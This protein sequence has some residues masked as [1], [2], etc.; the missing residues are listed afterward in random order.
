V[1]VRVTN[2]LGF[3]VSLGC[4]GWRYG[5]VGVG[6]PGVMHGFEADD[7]DTVGVGMR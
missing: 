2:D 7:T 1:P 3:A 5:L 6:C 4:V